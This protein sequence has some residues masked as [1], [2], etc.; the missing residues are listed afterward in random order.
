MQ[1]FS[2]HPEGLALRVDAQPFTGAPADPQFDWRGI[3]TDVVPRED[4]AL[5]VVDEYP[6]ALDRLAQFAQ[7]NNHPA[8]AAGFAAQAAQVSQALGLTGK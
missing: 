6:A 2:T 5:L 4:I 3:L 1:G 7:Q 8:E